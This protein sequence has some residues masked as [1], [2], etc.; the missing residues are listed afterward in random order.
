MSRRRPFWPHRVPILIGREGESERGY[1]AFLG[2]F[3][4]EVGL[5]VHI[6]SMDLQPGGGDPL[7]IVQLTV[8]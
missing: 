7:A 4:D 6:D 5:A 1:V 3:A 2:R 8:R